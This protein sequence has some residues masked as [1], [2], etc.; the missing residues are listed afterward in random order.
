MATK[1][2]PTLKTKKVSKKD[3]IYAVG[4]RKTATARVRLFLKPGPILVN[5]QPIE[6]YFPGKLN[7]VFYLTPFKVTN[8]QE[9][10]SASIKVAGSGKQ[11]QLGAVMHGLSRAL[12][13]FDKEK[14]RPLLRE[15]GLLTR[16][17]RV[18]ERRKVGTGGKARRQKQSPK[19]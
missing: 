7:Q 13:N 6:E 16:D 12:D 9:K 4:R 15:K 18:R 8:N 17:S 5:G 1:T 2:E 11:A 3:F 14:F 10:F 19:R